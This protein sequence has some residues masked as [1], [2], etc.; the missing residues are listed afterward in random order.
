V[1]L[2]VAIVL[3]PDFGSV[4]ARALQRGIGTVVGAVGGAILLVLVHGTW[5]LIPFG[6]LAALLPVVQGAVAG[7]GAE[8]AGAPD[9]ARRLGDALR[10]VGEAARTGMPLAAV[11]DLPDDEILKPVSEAIRA[12][13]S[14][15]GPGQRLTL[16]G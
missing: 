6:L 2:T 9:G 10:A 3:K 5:L 13:L 11:P 1:P 8:N 4:F 7:Q 16:Q 15:F 14:V 12:L